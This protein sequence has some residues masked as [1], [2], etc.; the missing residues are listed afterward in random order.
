MNGTKDCSKCCHGQHQINQQ[1]MC[2][3]MATL[4]TVE[5]MRHLRSEC[6][7]GANLYLPIEEDEWTS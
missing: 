1:R 7:P 4:H 3:R 5:Y 6:G 2:D